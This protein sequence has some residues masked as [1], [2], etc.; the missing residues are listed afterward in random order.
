MKV[1]IVS[2]TCLLMFTL[3]LPGA[4]GGDTSTVLSTS[5]TPEGKP[6]FSLVGEFWLSRGLGLRV[7]DDFGSFVKGQC[8]TDWPIVWSSAPLQKQEFSEGA[9]PVKLE[10]CARVPVF[11]A[12][13]KTC[14][15]DEQQEGVHA[16]SLSDV[17][18][19]SGKAVP[20]AILSPDEFKNQVLKRHSSE[21]GT[22]SV[23]QRSA[24]PI[25]PSENASGEA[26]S[27]E[28][29][30]QEGLT[31]ESESVSEDE[32]GNSTNSGGEGAPEGYD[33]E[34]DHV[35]GGRFNYAS[36]DAGAV[37]M[38]SS[39]AFKSTSNL[40]TENRDK[41]SLAPC[42]SKK[43]VVVGLSEDILVDTIVIANFE[44]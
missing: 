19:N 41:Y 3:I 38:A 42:K 16:T 26:G 36:F 1:P 44:R 39:E 12:E 24:Q 20:L 13:H 28:H 4:R 14:A 33:E 2:S 27:T 40:L 34:D 6:T 18:S 35:H 30:I 37:I 9:F 25:Q 10:S 31:P 8:T 43:W 7:T 11:E 22:S 15:K 17:A 29:D 23:D 21:G 32:E 5:V